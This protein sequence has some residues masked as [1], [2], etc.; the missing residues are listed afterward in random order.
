MVRGVVADVRDRYGIEAASTRTS[1]PGGL[2]TLVN[3]A[4]VG[5]FK[6]REHVRRQR[7]QV[8]DTNLTGAFCHADRRSRIFGRPAA[9]DHQHRGPAG[10]NYRGRRRVL[11][12]EAGLV[13]SASR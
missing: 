13:R 6:H 9:V 3:N 7:R 8:I 1:K 4:G 5:V 11:R 12:A 10:R 2:D